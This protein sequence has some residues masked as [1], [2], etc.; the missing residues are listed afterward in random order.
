MS[1]YK[2]VHIVFSIIQFMFSTQ[3][4]YAIYLALQHCVMIR[5]RLFMA[6]SYSL[7]TVLMTM[8]PTAAIRGLS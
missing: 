7:A 1:S 4:V 8:L 5:L 3:I 6:L 2:S